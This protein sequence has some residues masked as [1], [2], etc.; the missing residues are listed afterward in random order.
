ME[1][2]S[3]ET[4][5]TFEPEVR[6]LARKS[7]WTMNGGEIEEVAFCC[8]LYESW[9]KGDGLYVLTWTSQFGPVAKSSVAK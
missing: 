7:E 8:Q 4:R 1:P 3:E 6:R 2:D 9:R 5:T